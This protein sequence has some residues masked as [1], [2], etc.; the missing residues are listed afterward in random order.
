MVF[1][2]FSPSALEQQHK[3]FHA[4]SSRIPHE[5]VFNVGVW[6][7]KLNYQPLTL[8]NP[9]QPRMQRPQNISLISLHCSPL[10]QPRAFLSP[11]PFPLASPRLL[12]SLW[13]PQWLHTQTPLHLCRGTAD[14]RSRPGLGAGTGTPATG[15]RFASQ[16][17]LF[18]CKGGRNGAARAQPCLMVLSS[19][20][21]E[22]GKG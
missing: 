12:P 14:P 19:T 16:G 21:Q 18:F 4:A 13:C 17:W 15:T 9:H 20:D 1:V 6:L 7:F 2:P 5:E 11:S 22:Q 10:R 3:F 8:S